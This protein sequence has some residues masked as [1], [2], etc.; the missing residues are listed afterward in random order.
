MDRGGN[1]FP[2]LKVYLGQI[3]HPAGPVCPLETCQNLNTDPTTHKNRCATRTPWC[4][5][6]GPRRLL[7][8]L[9]SAGTPSA[10][11]AWQM[12]SLEGLPSKSRTVWRPVS[13]KQWPGST[14]VSSDAMGHMPRPHW[15]QRMTDRVPDRPQRQPRN[16]F[17][18]LR[19]PPS[20]SSRDPSSWRRGFFAARRR[21]KTSLPSWRVVRKVTCPAREQVHT[22]SRFSFSQT[23]TRRPGDHGFFPCCVPAQEMQACAAPKGLSARTVTS[24]SARMTARA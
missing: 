12:P 19:R 13:S 8:P 7:P 2:N 23:W 24:P 20:R 16:R 17:Q 14:G 21:T 18:R 10:S 11:R 5:T 6:P 9:V 15:W 22:P 1:P 3:L 4:G